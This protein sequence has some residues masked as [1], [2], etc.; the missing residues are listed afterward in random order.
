MT[1]VEKTADVVTLTVHAVLDALIPL[2]EDLSRELPHTERYRRLLET[3][4]TLFPGDAAAF[5]F[6]VQ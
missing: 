6:D 5:R 1:R 4:R 3:L 2:V